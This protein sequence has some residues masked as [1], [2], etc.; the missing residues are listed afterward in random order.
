MDLEISP[1][2]LAHAGAE[3][4]LCS[5]RLEDAGL[6]FGRTV[7]GSIDGLGMQATAATLA[8][9]G[10]TEHAVGELALDIRRLAHALQALAAHYP[11]VDRGAMP[12]R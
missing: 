9:A 4:A 11:R 12:P 2:E 5:T 8:A 7:Q 3:L 1:G 6:T 10:A